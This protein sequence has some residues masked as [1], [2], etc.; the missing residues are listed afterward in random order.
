MPR[1]SGADGAEMPITYRIDESQQLVVTTVLGR[2][3]EAEVRAHAAATARDPR[4]QACV[5]AI[6]D[7]GESAEASF[8]TK[9]ISDLA[10]TAR[11]LEDLSARKVALIAPSDT[12]YGLA[13]VFQGF[14]EGIGGG[15]VQV[16]R[17]RPE[18]EAWLGLKPAPAAP[19]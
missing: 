14:R 3:S 7:I 8:D 4:V 11:A 18:G 9:V 19:C 1:D 16:F 15:D 10:M 2:I 17:G 5:R 12:S 13:R 6:V